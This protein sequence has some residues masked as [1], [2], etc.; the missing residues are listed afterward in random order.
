MRPVS[1]LAALAFA[2]INRIEDALDA[3]KGARQMDRRQDLHDRINRMGDREIDQY[4]AL[5]TTTGQGQAE[6]ADDRRDRIARV[7]DS[8]KS[9]GPSHEPIGLGNID[10]VM[11]YQPWGPLETSAGD[12]VREALTAAA[13]AILRNVA[14]G[15]YRDKAID[16]IVQARMDANAAISF[17]G[18]F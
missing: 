15:R 9:A 8:T 14:P 7:Q 16:G 13:K 11:A 6:P 18:R 4:H 2:A 10:D 1:W 5:I 3:F 12:Q 17:R